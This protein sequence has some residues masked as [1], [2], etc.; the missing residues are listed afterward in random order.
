VWRRTQS[1]YEVGVFTDFVGVFITS[2]NKSF[3]WEGHNKS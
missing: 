2:S 1:E 3:T